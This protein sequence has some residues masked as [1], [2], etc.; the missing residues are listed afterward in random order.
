MEGRFQRLP[1]VEH[2]NLTDQGSDSVLCRGPANQRFEQSEV[3]S[4]GGP[5][6]EAVVAVLIHPRRDFSASAL[7]MLAHLRGPTQG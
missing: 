5:N 6:S 2:A 4:G 1:A 7:P 3:E